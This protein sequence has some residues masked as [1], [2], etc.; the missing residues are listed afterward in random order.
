MVAFSSL[1]LKAEVSSGLTSSCNRVFNCHL[2][3]TRICRCCK[4]ETNCSV[5]AELLLAWIGGSG[6][7]W[8]KS[9]KPMFCPELLLSVWGSFMQNN[10]LHYCLCL[11]CAPLPSPSFPGLTISH[12]CW[13]W[14]GEVRGITWSGPCS[15]W[16]SSSFWQSLQMLDW[17]GYLVKSNSIFLW[18]VFME[19]ESLEDFIV[20]KYN[21]TSGSI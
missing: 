18:S 13:L 9:L 17:Q 20:R 12:V 5:S 15:W 6:A 16:K 19:T 11:L 1:K 3:C 21:M 4:Q 7:K 10:P 2:G 8:S 14:T